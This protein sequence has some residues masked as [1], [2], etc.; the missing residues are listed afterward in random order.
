MTRSTLANR[1]FLAHLE[2]TYRMG[3]KV[4]LAEFGELIAKQMGRGTPFTA[5]AVSRW[6]NGAQAPTPEVIEAIAALTGIDPGW[7]S[8]GEKSA[9]PSPRA[10]LARTNASI[11]DD[12]GSQLAQPAIVPPEPPRTTG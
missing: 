3:R 11:V 10:Q 4:T 5:G 7:I 12:S 1:I 9:A 8:H 2:L 6:H